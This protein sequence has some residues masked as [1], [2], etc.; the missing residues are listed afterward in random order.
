M[1]TVVKPSLNSSIP[2]KK[3]GKVVI[4]LENVLMSP[5]KL[6]NSPSLQDGL[7][8]D[9]ELDLRILGCELIQTSGILLRLPQVRSY[10]INPVN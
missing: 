1:A 5:D 8:P 7:D 10:Y 4:T 9:T 3:Y 2:L 6:T